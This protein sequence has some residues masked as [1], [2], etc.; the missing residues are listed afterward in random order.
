M[1][2]VE[3]IED[4][5][6]LL[7]HDTGILEIEIGRLSQRIGDDLAVSAVKAFRHE[8]GEF[9]GQHV[10]VQLGDDPPVLRSELLRE[11]AAP[12]EV[13]QL[14]FQQD[15]FRQLHFCGAGEIRQDAISSRNL[16]A[17]AAKALCL[18]SSGKFSAMFLF[19]SSTALA[20]RSEEHTSELQ[21][22]E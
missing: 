12:D 21:S 8:M 7:F 17:S 5:E 13:I 11:V 9:V 1:T 6:K 16:N 22:R 20:L 3:K 14:V 19:T 10:I 4:H 2:V 15:E 18:V